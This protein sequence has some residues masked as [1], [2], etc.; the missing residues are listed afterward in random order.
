M[1]AYSLYMNGQL[2][3]FLKKTTKHHEPDKGPQYDNN[4]LSIQRY[5]LK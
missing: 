3:H 4:K 5:H 2:I 1:Q